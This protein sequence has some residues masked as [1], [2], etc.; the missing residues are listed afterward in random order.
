MTPEQ[1]RSAQ[2][3]FF[4][5]RTTR[6]VGLGIPF[7][8]QAALETGGA[9]TLNSE[10]GKGTQ[11]KAEF[12]LNSVDRMPMGKLEE[13]LALLIQS[14]PDVRFLLEFRCDGK[15]FRFDTEEAK[16][17]LQG[18]PLN[19]VSV[20]TFLKDYLKENLAECAGDKEI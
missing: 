8:R 4:T 12:V 20:V 14:S 16:Q 17:I 19:D 15:A 9:F 2:D 1:I 7:F 6:S 18:V 10:K 3:P 11:V 5:T 13:T